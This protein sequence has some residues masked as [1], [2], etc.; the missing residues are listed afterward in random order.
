MYII[1]YSIKSHN[2]NVNLDDRR[3]NMKEEMT[4]C[5]AKRA[6]RVLCYRQDIKIA[7]LSFKTIYVQTIIVKS[8]KNRKQIYEFNNSKKEK[9]KD[10]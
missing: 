3:I 7:I 1:D 9:H 4:I 2:L 8:N 5:L 10:S 6:S